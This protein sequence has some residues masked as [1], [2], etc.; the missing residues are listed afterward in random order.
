MTV[1]KKYPCNGM[2]AKEKS[3]TRV[4]QEITLSTNAV[5]LNEHPKSPKGSASHLRG[6]WRLKNSQVNVKL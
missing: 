3:T 6:E 1:N 5:C 4:G 2:I